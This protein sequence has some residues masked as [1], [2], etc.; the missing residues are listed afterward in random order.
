MTI[1]Q[2][3]DRY[4]DRMAGAAASGWTKAGFGWCIVLGA[5]GSVVAVNDLHDN[6]GRKPRRVEFN[7]P[8]G[9]KRTSG[10]APNF[11]WDKTSYTLGRTAGA[12]KRVMQEHEAFVTLHRERLAGVADA[13][14][15]AL[16]AFLENWR[17]ERFDDDSPFTDE[18]LDANIM[19]RLDGTTGYIHE[20]DEAVRLVDHFAADGATSDTVMCLVTGRQGTLERLHPAIK[21]VRDAQ[22][23]GAALVSF[24]LDAF[25]SYGQIQGANA[26]T[27]QEAAARYGGALNAMLARDSV[28][29]VSQPIGDATTV[30][31]A[32]AGEAETED[33]A[34]AAAAAE[35]WF[36]GPIE[37][38]TDAEEAE[39]LRVELEAVAAGRPISDVRPAI[40]KGTKF[41][42]L[43][44]SPN[45]ARLS[46][47]FWEEGDF[48]RFARRLADH[49]RDLTIKPLPSG[50]KAPS[51]SLLLARTT[52]LQGKFENIP[53]QL[54]GEVMRSV[55]TGRPYPR[56]WLSA[57]L[58]RLRAGD[59][60]SFGWHAAACRGV[61]HREYRLGFREREV[62]MALDRTHANPGYL[63]GRLFA[64]Y[65]LAQIAALGRGVNATMRDKF[66]GGASATPASIFPLVISNG[67]N[68]LAKAR[69]T[70]PGWAFLIER[71]LE[72]IMDTIEP[73]LPH[74]LPR[75]LPLED[76]A[77]FAIGYYHQ[78]S[79]KLKSDKGDEISLAEAEANATDNEGDSE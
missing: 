72:S 49:H 71:E 50:W 57:I 30:F 78:R 51:V 19:F 39:K 3:L 5:D 44:L 79:A 26:P 33:S 14:L 42:V 76:Q 60:P 61:L 54:A 20:S 64:V 23:S 56:S 68:H 59:D 22:S 29:R 6:S 12:G 53:N 28:N 15:K 77:E 55:L 36:A 10:I 40:A 31:W 62:P 9:P 1:L 41:H 13:G 74:T 17:P 21:G 35:A 45:A 65:E 2:A 66:F 7:V 16:L 25:T 4:Y 47:R 32:D 11:L 48:E 73:G 69:K 18:M 58:I 38:I 52:A 37:G 75:A 46:V 24:N 67:Q 27:S 8:A 63:L 34:E 43:G 70:S